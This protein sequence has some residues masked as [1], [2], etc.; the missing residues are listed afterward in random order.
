MDQRVTFKAFTLI[1]LLVVIA[2]ISLLV[3]ILLPSL[4]QAQDLA[5][6]AVCASNQR[7]LGLAILQYANTYDGVLTPYART[8]QGEYHNAAPLWYDL[9]AQD[10]LLS[11]DAVSVS[12]LGILR[13]PS[14]GREAF[15][16]RHCGSYS[17]NRFTMGQG[18]PHATFP[19][20]R[21]EDLDDPTTLILTGSG[22]NLGGPVGTYWSPY[23]A[24]VYWW[25]GRNVYGLGFTWDRHSRTIRYADSHVYGARA[26]FSLVDGH[27]EICAG[28][29]DTDASYVRYNSPE[30]E[31]PRLIP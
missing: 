9:L 8:G 30:G 25:I 12:G 11:A 6:N 19:L 14:D 27:A 22:G 1:E 26:V 7:Q 13:C 3:S 24:S 23:G 21:V 10:G 29:F 17:A 16:G 5:R 28:D 15:E 4:M 20:R 18:T 2:I 31:F